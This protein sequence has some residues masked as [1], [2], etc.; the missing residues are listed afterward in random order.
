MSNPV[1]HPPH[2]NQ[3]A[4]ECIDAIAAALTSEEFAG[5]CKGNAIKYLWR[6]N[7]KGG[8]TDLQKAQ[9]YLGRLTTSL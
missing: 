2:Y 4:I 1:D 8:A 3:G 9:W 7:H 6:A 5:F